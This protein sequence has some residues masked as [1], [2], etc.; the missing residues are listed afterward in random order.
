MG[1]ISMDQTVSLASL[2][3]QLRAE[4]LDARRVFNQVVVHSDSQVMVTITSTPLINL[5]PR[6]LIDDGFSV[7]ELNIRDDIITAVLDRVTR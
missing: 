7:R 5:G 1:L 4:G 3:S 2:T 6:F